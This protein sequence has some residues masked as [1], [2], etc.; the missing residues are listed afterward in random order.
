MRRRT[1]FSIVTTGAV[2][3][4]CIFLH[5][6]A[7]SRAGSVGTPAFPLSDLGETWHVHGLVANPEPNSAGWF[8]MTLCGTDTGST[9]RADYADSHGWAESDAY[10]YR[11][12]ALSGIGNP[13]LVFDEDPLGGSMSQDKG[14]IASVGLLQ[15]G[16]D[17]GLTGH[18][19]WIWQKS[20]GQ[21]FNAMDLAGVWSISSLTTGSQS[22]WAHGEV[23]INSV[24]VYYYESYLDDSQSTAAPHET[25]NISTASDGTLRWSFDVTSHG[26]LSDSKDF[27][28]IV[29]GNAPSTLSILQKRSGGTF[30]QAD[31]AGTWFLDGLA[32]GDSSQIGAYHGTA[33]M[34]SVTGSM[35]LTG[36]TTLM[37][38]TKVEQLGLAVSIT[39]DGV[40]TL[41][42]LDSSYGIM[43]DDK[44]RIIVTFNDAAGSPSLLVMTRTTSSLRP[45]YR[46]WS[47]RT[48]RHFFTSS[49]AERN[50][51]IITCPADV[52]T[53]EGIAY[54]AFS[55]ASMT[56]L[57]PVYR[58]WSAK[59]YTHFYTNSA[60][61]R[62]KLI[63][64]YSDVW[65]YELVA[66]YA[67]PNGQEPPGCDPVYRFWSS[68]YGTHFYT[69]SESEKN[70]LVNKY[71][72]VW[73]LESVA[74]YAYP[75]Q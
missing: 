28:V 55:S 33:V 74:W 44:S 27:A 63:N 64:K 50:K 60:S 69:I 59:L 75:Y 6:A 22:G 9:S 38:G 61:E 30:S 37:G 17:E 35:L 32:V 21:T 58:F 53:Y 26:T 15:P 10:T 29:S 56:G 42:R 48:G 16:P 18:N 23:S 34:D 4:A 45:V 40:V 51:L 70:K 67:Y 19:L 49:I 2:L 41:P 3:T 47:P 65:K 72:N 8:H 54:Y 52:W 14:T 57:T 24:G 5:A 20:S 1:S 71:S 11:I 13:S 68:R 12:F 36:T 25:G 31:L 66:F 43:S 73:Q 39:S 46:F 62:D 7:V